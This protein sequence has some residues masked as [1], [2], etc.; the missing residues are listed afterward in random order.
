MSESVLQTYFPNL[1]PSSQTK[2]LPSDSFIYPD[3]LAPL[4]LP[5]DPAD[6]T[7]IGIQKVT[8]FWP[9]SVP[10]FMFTG[11]PYLQERKGHVIQVLKLGRNWRLGNGLRTAS[12]LMHNQYTK[13]FLEETCILDCLL[14]SVSTCTTFS[15]DVVYKLDQRIYQ[16]LFTRLT[17]LRALASLSLQSWGYPALQPPVWPIDISKGLTANDFEI[18]ALQYRICVENF[19]YM[20]DDVHDWDKGQTRVYLDEELLATQRNADRSHVK[21]GEYYLPAVPPMPHPYPSKSKTSFQTSVSNSNWGRVH[22]DIP[23]DKEQHPSNSQAINIRGQSCLRVN[24]K[25]LDINIRDMAEVNDVQGK[26]MRYS[27]IHGKDV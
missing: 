10:L 26:E 7:D 14:T 13:I 25:D 9:T 8:R 4:V 5:F 17:N 22:H 23:R 20:L 6:I 16:E 3:P 19:L 24:S 21:N 18:Y 1:Q 12:S 27:G 11:H 2:P 15:K